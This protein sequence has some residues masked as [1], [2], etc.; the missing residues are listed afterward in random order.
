MIW[1]GRG[2]ATK[3]TLSLT[4]MSVPSKDHPFLT[5]A[6]LYSTKNGTPQA[7]MEE[8]S[9]RVDAYKSFSSYLPLL[10]CKPPIFS[11]RNTGSD[12]GV[13]GT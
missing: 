6:L 7:R 10:T 3:K 2:R 8:G 11:K 1:E 4:I 9:Q 5:H 12:H 13:T